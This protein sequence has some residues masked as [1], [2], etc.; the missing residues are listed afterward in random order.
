MT[1][2]AIKARTRQLQQVIFG[3]PTNPPHEVVEFESVMKNPGEFAAMLRP[4]STTIW[5]A[6][7]GQSPVEFQRLMTAAR[8]IANDGR[9]ARYVLHIEDV[10]KVVCCKDQF[11][12]FDP[13]HRPKLENR[14]YVDTYQWPTAPGQTEAQRDEYVGK[15]TRREQLQNNNVTSVLLREPNKSAWATIAQA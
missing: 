13:A 8:K 10:E 15:I 5:V 14:I 12:I 6:P 11:E 2:P 7:A 9:P 4:D 3:R 1:D